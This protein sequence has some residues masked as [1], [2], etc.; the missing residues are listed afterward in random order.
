MEYK[1]IWSSFK[2]DKICDS[3]DKDCSFDVVII[4]GGITGISTAFHLASSDLNVCLVEKN[5][6]C[7]GVTSRTTGKLTYL[8]EDIYSK[9][10]KYMGSYCSKLYLKSQIDAIEIV[11]DIINTYRIDCNLEKVKSYVFSNDN[12]DLDKDFNLL[13]NFGINL[14]N[15]YFLPTHDRVKNAYYVYDTYV[16]NP[17]KYLYSLK[18]ICI[19]KGVSIYENT[20]VIDIVKEDGYFICKTYKNKIKT[21]YVVLALHYPY[22]LFPFLMPFKSS[23]EKSYIGAFKTDK[24]LKFSSISVSKPTVSSRY[25]DGDNI[26]ELF[27]TNS[28]NTCVRDNYKNN[29]N[30]LISSKR[31][32]YSYLWSNKDIMTNDSLPF[33]G[34]I[35]GSNLLIGTGYNTWGMTNGSLAGKIIADIILGNNNKYISLFSPDRGINV[36][37]I[38]KFPMIL[39]SNAYSFIKS[40]LFK[41]KYWYSQNIEFKKIN[42]K[43][44]AIY[45]DEGNKKHM[46]YNLCPHLKCSL[47]F[48]EV[49]K[50]WDCPCHGSRFD[51]DG[52]CI[53]GPSNYDISYR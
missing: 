13:K 22:F 10:E 35:N 50:T 21:K 37:K 25:Y 32:K 18:D 26:Y 29:F 45:T 5:E 47:I 14:K 51:V 33:I 40:K 38:I 48:N 2:Q 28:H 6:I 53:E 41:Q 42:G 27:L 1:S 23:I 49:E 52:K 9:L 19:Q 17:L 34:R 11:K 24:N 46:V 44:I 15:A 4:G 31:E 20:K 30:D 16:F 43:N 39:G 12:T 3:L 8:Q 36:L 7:S